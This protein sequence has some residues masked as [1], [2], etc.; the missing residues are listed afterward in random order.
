MQENYSI[1]R[2]SQI[3]IY[4]IAAIVILTKSGGKKKRL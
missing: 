1:T 4:K 2:P 3:L